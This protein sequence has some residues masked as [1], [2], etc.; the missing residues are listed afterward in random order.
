MKDFSK[1]FETV[2]NFK[3]LS[4]L[5]TEQ[6]LIKQGRVHGYLSRVRVGRGSDGGQW[7]IWAGAVSS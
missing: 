7:G 2:M 4:F 1:L 3:G 6:P 5:V